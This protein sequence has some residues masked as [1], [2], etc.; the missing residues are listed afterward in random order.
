M[1]KVGFCFLNHQAHVRHQLPIAIEYS[2][3]NPDD[4]VDIIYTTDSVYEEISLNLQDY[5]SNNFNLN[6]LQGSFFK[7]LAGKIKG[8][9]YPNTKNVINTNKDAFLSYDVL[10]TPHNTLDRVMALDSERKIKYICIFH[11]A[12]DGEVGFDSRFSA[13]DLLL[14]SGKDINDRLELEEIVHANNESKIIGYPKLEGIKPSQTRCFDNG[15][16]TYLFNP[17]YEPHLTSW[18]LWGEDVLKWFS[19]NPEHNLIFSPH[20]KLFNGKL[21]DN[22]KK[23]LEFPNIYVDV[24]SGRMMDA[25]YTAQADVY[26]GDVSSQV[27]EFL[28]FGA[29]PVLFLNAIGVKDWRSDPCYKM[30]RMGDVVNSKKDIGPLIVK[31]A[32]RHKETYHDVQGGL[33]KNKFSI[34]DIPASVR[35]AKAISEF[36]SAKSSAKKSKS[37]KRYLLYIA[38]NYSYEILRPI[39]AEIISRGGECAW[40]IA[41]DDVNSSLLNQ[42]EHVL[43]TISDIKVY[44]PRA[45]LVPGYA[46]PSFLPGLKVQIF[47]GL[48]WKKKGHFKIRDYFDLYCT[49]GPI[50]TDKFNEL[51]I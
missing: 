28:Y 10:V 18:P 11:G 30:W 38:Q 5:E 21:P 20:V 46:V 13:Y 14:T 37:P 49:F 6:K 33:L 15:N 17:H 27:Y 3:M 42:N 31:C 22:L 9:L 39:Q 16:L 48:E 43:N 50:T 45:V 32:S 12:G 25:T 34:T 35:G 8:R 24:N 23:Y 51:K 41:S 26:I 47:H 2:R 7:T 1:I 29:R 40:F 4:Q 19:L 36:I 44:S